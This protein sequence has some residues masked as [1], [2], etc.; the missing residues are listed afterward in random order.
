MTRD[1]LKLVIYAEGNTDLML[2]HLAGRDFTELVEEF[3]DMSGLERQGSMLKNLT[4]LADNRGL[5]GWVLHLQRACTREA[6]GW[7]RSNGVGIADP[8]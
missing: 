7:L 3:M 6:V 1:E 5:D 8:E 4:F 2:Y